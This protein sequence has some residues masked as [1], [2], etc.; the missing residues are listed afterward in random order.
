MEKINIAELL[1]DCPEG[2]ELDSPVWDNIEFDRIDGDN[3]VIFRKHCGS[4][5]YLTQFGGMS[6]V[7]GKC[8]IFPKG[9]TTWEGFQRPFKDGDVVIT[10]SNAICIYK[11]IH[12]TYK[13]KSLIDYYC[14]YR[15]SDNQLVIKKDNDSHFGFISEAKFATEEEKQ[16]LFQAIKDNGYHWNAET[17]TLET[18]PRFKVGNRIRYAGDKLVIKIIDIKDNQ[19]HIKCFCDEYNIYKCGIISVSEQNN[20][21][22]VPKFNIA[23]LK[24]F[25]KVLVRLTKDSVWSATFFSHYNKKAKL[26]N[27]PFVTTSDKSYPMCIPYEENEHLLGTTNDCEEFYKTW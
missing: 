26:G 15:T 27:Y 25:D 10:N 22:L 7:D 20:Y 21:I 6:G 17:K 11:S 1:K 12:K 4:R 8:I 16:K 18:L 23:T 13:S 14:G 2:M 19:Y 5:V 3:I 24:P 9:K